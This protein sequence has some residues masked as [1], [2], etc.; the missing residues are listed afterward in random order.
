MPFQMSKLQ[1]CAFGVTKTAASRLSN[2]D[3]F[4]NESPEARHRALTV[5]FAGEPSGRAMTEPASFSG[6]GTAVPT[7]CRPVQEPGETGR[8]HSDNSLAGPRIPP[9][10]HKANGKCRVWPDFE[11]LLPH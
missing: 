1:C 4:F 2:Y 7:S 9:S 6:P 11:S 8:R 10:Q 3:E 5:I